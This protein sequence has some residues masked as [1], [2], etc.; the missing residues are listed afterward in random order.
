MTERDLGLPP[1][2]TGA[3]RLYAVVGD[4]IRQVGSPGV[5]NRLFREA[6]IAA[7]LVPMQ[8]AQGDFARWFECV[9]TIGNLD[10]F[11]A[12]MP[13]KIEAARLADELSPIA[14]RVGAANVIRRDSDGRWVGHHTDGI[15]CIAG[16]RSRGVGIE[17]ARAAQLGAGGVGRAIAF[18][19]AEAGLAALRLHDAD[20]GRLAAL[21][22][23]LARAFPKLTLDQ[24][25]SGAGNLD[26]L[27]N[28]TPLGMAPGDPLPFDLADLRAGTALADVIL[29]PEV[30]PMLAHARELGC[31]TQTGH[32]MVRAQ[33]GLIMAHLGLDGAGGG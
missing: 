24:G 19:L 8:V 7:V 30:S 5:F 16:L 25:P 18:A 23:D 14:E 17:G 26:L 6:G 21:L 4:P 12:T 32:E 9:R 1:P 10:G 2:I 20:E 29:A 22:D 27:V 33:A 3:T 15:G 11:V 28:A 31:I 13:H